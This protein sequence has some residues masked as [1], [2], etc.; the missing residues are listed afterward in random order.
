M[1]KPRF[2]LSNQALAS[3]DRILAQTDI[4]SYSE[5]FSLLLRRYEDDFIRATN[6]FFGDKVGQKVTLDE[7]G[8]INEP[9][10]NNSGQINPKPKSAKQQLMD[11]ED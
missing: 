9:I 7:Q 6:G 2:S 10:K 4:E 3:A 8:G 11:F 1:N 5:L